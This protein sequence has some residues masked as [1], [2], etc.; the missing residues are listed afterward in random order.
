[1]YSNTLSEKKEMAFE[2]TH[3]WRYCDINEIVK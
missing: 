2:L 3:F 1:M